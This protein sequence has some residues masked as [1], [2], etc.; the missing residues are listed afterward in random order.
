MRPVLEIATSGLNTANTQKK[1][2]FRL[3][4]GLVHSLAAGI[5]E[6]RT[7][8]PAITRHSTANSLTK[9]GFDQP[10]RWNLGEVIWTE[11]E[12]VN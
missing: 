6:G 4:R 2:I 5:E 3:N 8:C 11:A 12:F 10:G 9:A 7:M 1:M